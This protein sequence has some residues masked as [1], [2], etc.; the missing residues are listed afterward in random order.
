MQPVA[1]LLR[2]V[3]ALPVAFTLAGCC[4][5]DVRTVTVNSSFYSWVGDTVAVLAFAY[6]DP[7]L[8]CSAVLYSSEADPLR[9]RYT[10]SNA[11]VASLDLRGGQ[12]ILTARAPGWT[13]LVAVTEGV[14]SESSLV[15]VSPAIASFRVTFT[16]ATGL[17]GDTITVRL[18]A[19]DGSGAAMTNALV[20]PLALI[21]PSDTLASWLSP[22]SP[23]GPP[24]YTPVVDR[25]VVQ[26]A[27]ALRVLAAAPYTVSGSVNRIADT[28]TLNVVR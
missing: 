20:W 27:G 11:A 18:D 16:P 21:P 23:Y 24:T 9:F 4:S 6:G 25:F 10:S 17:V 22:H 8:F 28:V 13:R 1:T 15:V 2:T 26:R 3:V 19:M 5:D 12:P 14:A 7:S